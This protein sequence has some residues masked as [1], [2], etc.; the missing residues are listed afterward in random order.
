MVILGG[1]GTLF[2]PVLGAAALLL[3]ETPLGVDGA[4]AGRSLARSW[5]WS[6]STPGRSVEPAARRCARQ[7]LRPSS[8]CAGS[9][10]RFG[11]LVAT[12]DVDARG[13][14]GRDARGHR[15]QRGRQDDADRPALGRSAARRGHHPV[16]RPRTSPRSARPHARTAGWPARFRSRASFATSPRSTTSRSPYRLTPVTRS[17]SGARP[18]RRQRC[19]SRPAPFSSVSAWAL[20]PTSW[21]ARSPTASSASWRS[22]MALATR[23]RLLLLDEPVAGMG[24]DES[25]RMVELLR[26]LRGRPHAGARRARHGRGVRAGRSHQRAGLRPRHRPPARRRRSAPTPRS[27]GAYL[28][29]DDQVVMT[30]IAARCLMLVVEGWRRRTG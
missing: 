23:P 26:A 29:E 4:L 6:C 25:Q 7:W 28:G 16:R 17:A 5:F 13:G 15:P 12:D 1:M 11:G 18:A 3:L 10:K 2:G 9:R 19:A 22:R 8:P 20:A 21:P 27:A 30:V 24:V 14:R